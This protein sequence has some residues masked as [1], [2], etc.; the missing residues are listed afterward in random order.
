MV[1]KDVLQKYAK[2]EDQ[3]IEILLDYQNVK[4]NHYITKEEIIEIAS[5]L[6][7]P[8]SKVC[9]VLSFYTFFSDKPRGKHIIQV[10]KD[11]PCYVSSDINVLK[12]IERELGIRVNETTPNQQFTLEYTSCLGCCEAGPAMRINDKIYTHLTADKIKAI[13]SEYRVYM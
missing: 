10:C 9:S 7:I 6:S 8:E 2:T 3:L 4:S 12:I 5:Y 1:L 11:V 13:L